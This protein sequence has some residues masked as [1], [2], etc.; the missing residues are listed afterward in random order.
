[1]IGSGGSSKN[2]FFEC[3]LTNTARHSSMCVCMYFLHT[4]YRINTARA[5]YLSQ[6][7]GISVN[8]YT[9]KRRVSY[10]HT[11]CLPHKHTHMQH[12]Q[13]RVCTT[14]PT[15]S[16]S[17]L[18]VIQHCAIFSRRWVILNGKNEYLPQHTHMLITRR[19]IHTKWVITESCDEQGSDCYGT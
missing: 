11:Q 17:L 19:P 8:R 6:V 2:T 15:H 13:T 1:M 7:Q 16:R 12:T 18:S 14:A 3:S 4:K 5:R 10:L 9:C